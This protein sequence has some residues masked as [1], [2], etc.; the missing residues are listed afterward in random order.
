[1]KRTIILTTLVIIASVF[2]QGCECPE[3]RAQAPE[4]DICAPPPVAKA[5]QYFP[6]TG[7][8]MLEKM[9]PQEVRANEQFNY[10]IKLTNTTDRRLSNV[11][12]TDQ[13]PANLRIE[14]SE[15]KLHRMQKNK[16]MWMIGMLEPE[17]SE[18]ITV[19]AIASGSGDVSSCASVTYDSPV[20]AK[21]TIVTPALAL[22]KSAPEET[23]SCDRIPVTYTITNNGDRPACNIAINDKLPKGMMTSEGSQEVSFKVDSLDVGQSRAFKVVLNVSGPGEFA[24]R[25]TAVSSTGGSTQ[26]NIPRTSVRQPVLKIS[27]AAPARDFVGKAVTFEF[28]VTNKGDGVANDTVIVAS[29]Q[30]GIEFEGATDQGVYTHSSPGQVTWNIGSIQPNSSKVVRMT[31]KSDFKGEL[32]SEATA[33]AHCAEA[34]TATAKTMIAG[35]PALLLEVIDIDDPVRIGDNGTY[36][37]TV[38]NQG[39]ANISNVRVSCQIEDQMSY[40]SSTGPTKAD[41]SGSKINFQPLPNLSPNDR[42]IWQITVKAVGPGDLR[43]KVEVESDQFKRPVNESEATTFYE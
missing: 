19:S 42:A 10:R 6:V 37:I 4:K 5:G 23:L 15:P 27:K 17:A 20:C 38:T 16:A 25:A 9:S 30:D 41:A 18:M 13:L 1:M 40:I 31:L 7:A 11:M 36:L 34:V 21:V 3:P 14:S 39:S 29:I 26:S 43:F 28:T 35:I 24:S 22:V 2:I 8:I 12:V 33:R 32:V